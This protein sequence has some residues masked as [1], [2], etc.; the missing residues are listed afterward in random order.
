MYGIVCKE[1]GKI[2]II[3]IGEDYCLRLYPNSRIAKS[4]VA[5][6]NGKSQQYGWGVK[7]FAIPLPSVKHYGDY[8]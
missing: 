3:D 6:M 2:T 1:N 8:R 7:Y 5:T 4:M